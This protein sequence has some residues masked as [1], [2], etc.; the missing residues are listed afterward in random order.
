MNRSNTGKEQMNR[1][2]TGYRNKGIDKTHRIYEQM[3][4]SN[5]G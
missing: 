4:R 3:I 2:N 5:T 1:S